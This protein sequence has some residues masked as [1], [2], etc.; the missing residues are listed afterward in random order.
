MSPWGASDWAT[1]KKNLFINNEAL[2]ATSQGPHT[3]LHVS[4]R[5]DLYR[6]RCPSPVL[7]SPPLSAQ[8]PPPRPAPS[9]PSPHFTTPLPLWTCFPSP[10]L[11]PV[12][13]AL[14]NLHEVLGTIFKTDSS[15]KLKLKKCSSNVKPAWKSSAEP[16]KQMH[17]YYILIKNKYSGAGDEPGEFCSPRGV[18]GSLTMWKSFSICEKFADSSVSLLLISLLRMACNKIGQWGNCLEM[19]PAE[20]SYSG[21]AQVVVSQLPYWTCWEG[22]SVPCIPAVRIWWT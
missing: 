14:L 8:P 18:P 10:G 20:C 4:A 6:W 11:S 21:N 15:S 2:R 5:P 3:K 13:E 22:L 12:S 17:V 7:Y 1:L 9:L 16:K 19:R